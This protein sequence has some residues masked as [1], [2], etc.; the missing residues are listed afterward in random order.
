M[1]DN[2]LKSYPSYDRG[3]A[4]QG[5]NDHLRNIMARRNWSGMCGY[6]I[7]SVPGQYT[8]GTVTATNN[9]N[10]LTGTSTA[11]E[12][13]DIVDTTLAATMIEAGIVDVTPTSMTGITTSQWL[14]I[15]G[16]NSGEEAVYVIRVNQ[17]EGTF[18]A[19][20][21]RTHASGVSI[22]CS[23]LMGR[24]LRISINVPYITITGVSSAT[25]LLLQSVWPIA[26]TSD[27]GYS[28]FLAITTLG[29]DVNQV[30]TMINTQNQCQF[31]LF[32][33]IQKLD[34]DDPT[35][36]ATQF[37][38]KLV[39][40]NPDPAG[41]P[42]WELYPRPIS[43]AAFPYIYMKEW[44]PLVNDNDLLPNGIRSDVLVKQVKADAARWPGH[45]LTDGGAYYDPNLG[46][47]LMDES[48]RD[49]LFMMRADD[50]TAIMTVFAQYQRYG[51]GPGGNFPN[52]GQSH[53]FVVGEM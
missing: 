11:W 34:W 20:F 42:M 33:P 13:N 35:R 32:T 36:Q 41:T 29:D 6:S 14:L 8:T 21:T 47:K 15:D 25:R 12:T 17:E 4:A 5:I 2:V 26:T 3:L 28:I 23:S 31:D 19:R 27:Q 37:P 9:S 7:L 18:Q 43:Q 51:I 38:W 40:R 46:S 50:S 45:K 1:V 16:G 49:I 30:L 22:T 53:D 44:T 48:E 24:Q 39:Y 10:V 52:Y